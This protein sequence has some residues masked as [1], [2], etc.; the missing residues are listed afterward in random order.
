MNNRQ[1]WL[2]DD[3]KDRSTIE[4]LSG[5]GTRSNPVKF[6]SYCGSGETANFVD[7]ISGTQISK[8]DY[9]ILD[10]YMPIPSPIRNP[11]YWNN[12]VV[13]DEMRCGFALAKWLII[14]KNVSQNRIAMCSAFPNIYQM[15]MEFG[16]D[17]SLNCWNGWQAVTSLKVRKWLGI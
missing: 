2:V 4:R 17:D 16:F 9:F 12:L 10:V 5:T 11:K 6:N 7:V 8:N 13:K 14:E 3:N 15:R 1:V